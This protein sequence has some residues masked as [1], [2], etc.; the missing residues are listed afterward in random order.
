MEVTFK[1][2]RHD[3]RSG[4]EP[5]QQEYTVDAAP[6]ATVFDALV[7][8]REEQDGSL[9]F[10]GNCARGFCGD[11]VVRMNGKLTLSCL[12]PVEK[13]VKDG[14]IAV[15]SAPYARPA[16]DVM[17]DNQTFL[18]DKYRAMKP[19]LVSDGKPS[20]PVTEEAM[21]EVRTTMRCT[22]CGLCDFGCTVI[23]V[24]QAFMGPA[25]LTKAYRFMLDPR[26][27]ATKERLTM[28]G[29]PKGM[30]DCVHCWE[31]SEHCPVGIEPT[32]RIMDMRDLAVRHGVKSGTQNPKV[33]RH[34]DSFAKSVKE[35]GW[36]DE[37]KITLDTEGI[38][39]SLRL[40]PIA[41]KALT[42]GKVAVIHPKRSGAEHIRRIFEKVEADF[43]ADQQ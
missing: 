19:W 9:G 2:R 18:W 3:P 30:W 11:C 12:T 4:G 10:R 39:G 5:S 24:D 23:D 35:S 21:A 37:F 32:H 31:A 13:T 22:M 41:L 42:R 1:V 8:I 17:Y 6:G 7:Q 15:D 29:E 16:K 43:K 14:V 26:D 28:A 36:L 27:T 20:K 40:A 34:Y 33:A 38:L 25:A